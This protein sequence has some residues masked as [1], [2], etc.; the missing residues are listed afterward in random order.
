MD[1]G[2][3]L[4]RGRSNQAQRMDLRTF[5]SVPY[6]G[7]F[8]ASCGVLNVRSGLS[9]P[10]IATML[11]VGRVPRSPAGAVADYYADVEANACKWLSHGLV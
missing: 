1:R 3:K 8:P 10:R 2:E 5:Q 9:F 6:G 4:S 11:D 7:V